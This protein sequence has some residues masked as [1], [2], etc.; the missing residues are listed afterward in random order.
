MNK[1]NTLTPLGNIIFSGGFTVGVSTDIYDKTCTKLIRLLLKGFSLFLNLI[2]SSSLSSSSKITTAK[3]GLHRCFGNIDVLIF[4]STLQEK[5]DKYHKWTDVALKLSINTD[6]WL[7]TT[8]IFFTLIFG[9]YV[10]LCTCAYPLATF[11][12]L[13]SHLF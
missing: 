13:Y 11:I 6:F 8:G 2:M 3:H 9:L 12:C 1:D 5:G 4:G 7:Y 10:V